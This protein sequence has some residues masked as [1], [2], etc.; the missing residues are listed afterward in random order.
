MILIKVATAYNARACKMQ[1]LQPC[2]ALRPKGNLVPIIHIV[3]DVHSCEA[4]KIEYYLECET[5]P[6]QN[7]P[8]NVLSADRPKEESC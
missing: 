8:P 2:V 4:E 6:I 5:R 7:A 3:F 1:N